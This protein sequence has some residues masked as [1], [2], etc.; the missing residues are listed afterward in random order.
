MAVRESEGTAWAYRL[1]HRGSRLRR[2]RDVLPSPRFIGLA[3]TKASSGGVRAYGDPLPCSGG[4][5]NRDTE[6][7]ESPSVAEVVG[8]GEDAQRTK[9]S[10]AT[11]HA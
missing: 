10:H 9:N 8:I 5:W 3:P 1:W 11:N 7:V 4:S 2:W 6:I